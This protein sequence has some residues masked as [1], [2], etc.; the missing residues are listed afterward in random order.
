MKKAIV[1]GVFSIIVILILISAA[2][3]YKFNYLQ[4]DLY[5]INENNESVKLQSD[6]EFELGEERLS[7]ADFYGALEHYSKAVD[8]DEHNL[9]AQYWKLFCEY[10]VGE[11]AIVIK[12]GEE[13]IDKMKDKNQFTGYIINVETFI[14]LSNLADGKRLA[15]IHF[16]NGIKLIESKLTKERNIDYIMNKATL[17][18]YADRQDEA[19]DFIN[20]VEFTPEELKLFGD[21][22][23]EEII[24]NINVSEI[25]KIAK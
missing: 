3:I 18:C 23:P 25:L 8:I 17:L 13:L 22:S 6:E 10:N 1:I 16:E 19:I 12:Q 20:S 9:T 5:I 11:Y 21:Q 4:D 14:G 15:E 2:G 7:T 24:K